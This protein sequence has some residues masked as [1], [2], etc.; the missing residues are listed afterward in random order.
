MRQLA[1]RLGF[2]GLLTTGLAA[3]GGGSATA[4]TTGKIVITEISAQ[5]APEAGEFAG[6]YSYTSTVHVS[7]QT[8]QAATITKIAIVVTQG[9][10]PVYNATY[11][12]SASQGALAAG[13]TVTLTEAQAQ[14]VTVKGDAM[15]ITVTYTDTTGS[16]DLSLTARLTA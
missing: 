9:G 1:I 13:A 4:P 3:C 15:M 2:V 5:I 10:T 6:D 7:N 11:G 12:L 16:H 14:H 8:T